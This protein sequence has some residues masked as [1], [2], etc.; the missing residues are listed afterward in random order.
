MT[1]VR[2]N[3]WFLAASLS[4]FVTSMVT[5]VPHAQA[6]VE[7][8]SMEQTKSIGGHV[9]FLLPLVTTDQPG[10]TT[11]LVSNFSIG[12]PA[13]ITVAGSGRTAFDMEFVPIIQDSP[14][15]VTLTLHP[16]FLVRVAPGLALGLR[17]AFVANSTEY[18]FTPLVHKSW[19]IRSEGGFFKEYFAEADLPVRFNHPVTGPQSDPVTFALHFGLGF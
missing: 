7:P 11:T 19:R 9:G 18:G 15:S 12:F 5:A 17:A 8:H 4:L 14:R 16:G 2:S 6:Q 13:G 1:A 3:R 10:G